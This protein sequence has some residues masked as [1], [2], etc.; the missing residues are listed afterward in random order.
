MTGNA[1]KLPSAGGSYTRKSNGA[2]S[3]KQAPTKPPVPGGAKP[4]A[5][6]PQVT[7]TEEKGTDQ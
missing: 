7:E 4:A 5:P 3:Q 1:P 2:L 6:A